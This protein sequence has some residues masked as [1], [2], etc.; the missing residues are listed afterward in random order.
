MKKQRE[1]LPD[2][3]WVVA[4]ALLDSNSDLVPEYL[5]AS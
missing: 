5:S 3:F 4:C 1:N 2:V